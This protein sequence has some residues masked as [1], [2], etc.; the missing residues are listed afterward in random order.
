MARYPHQPRKPTASDSLPARKKLA[1]EL[2]QSPRAGS[3][4]P[5]RASSGSFGLRRNYV[6]PALAL[7]LWGLGYRG[8]APYPLEDMYKTQFGLCQR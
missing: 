3:R 6:T 8:S 7:H 4:G 1:P 5:V 2:G